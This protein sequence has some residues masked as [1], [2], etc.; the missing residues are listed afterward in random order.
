MHDYLGMTL[1]F[2]VEGKVK[3]IMKDYIQDM[4]DKL[5]SDMD[6]KAVNP[7]GEHLFT[8]N[9]NPV[10]L[11]EAT[12]TRTL[13]SYYSCRNGPDQTYSPQWHT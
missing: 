1:D 3:V 4:L 2:S 6:G 7:S 8:A 9:E 5:P 13:L 11:D 12:S 10:P